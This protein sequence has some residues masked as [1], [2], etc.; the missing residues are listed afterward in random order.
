VNIAVGSAFRNNSGYYLKRYIAQLR[1]L[2]DMAEIRGDSL[3]WIAVEGDSFDGTRSEIVE[4]GRHVKIPTALVSRDH[5][6]PVFQSTEEAARM[7]ALSY[8]G[9]GI[10]ESV[11]E[12]DDV[13]VYVESDLL[14]SSRAIFR[15]VDSLK[16]EN[17]DVISPLVFAGK[18][19]YDVWGFRGLDGERFAPFY[20]YHSDLD[21]TRLT[22]VS[23]V[24]SCLVMRG[25]VARTARIRNNGAL[26]GFCEDVRS[27]GFHI[28]VD[29]VVRVDHPC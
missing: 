26:V 14:W 5:G 15:L 11:L 19:F 17:V 27:L 21:F 10:L 3:R 20:P 9:N 7:K 12:S 23:S 22:E 4:L 1:D 6:G 13:L 2:K 29:S 18:N 16:E 24:G 8:V 25:I 28:W